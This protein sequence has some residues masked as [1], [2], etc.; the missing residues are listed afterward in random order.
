MP[1][2]LEIYPTRLKVED[3][4]WERLAASGIKTGFT[5]NLLT[6][7]E[8]EKELICELVHVRPISEMERGLL[9]HD[10]VSGVELIRRDSFLA[11]LASSDGFIRS[12]GELIQQFKL[13]LLN[14]REL[15]KIKLFAPSKERWIKSVFERYEKSLKKYQLYDNADIRIKLIESLSDLKGAPRCLARFSE[16]HFYDI[17]HYTPFRFELIRRLGIRMGVGE[18]LVIHFPLP[19]ER[20]KAFDFVERDIQKFQS[21]EDME[22]GLEIAFDTGGGDA[23]TALLNFSNLIFSEKEDENPLMAEKTADSLLITANSSRYREVEEVVSKIRSMEKGNWS[24]FCL[25]FRN[26]ENY[27]SI[28]EDVFRRADIPLYLRRGLPVKNNPLVR[29][30]LTVFTVIETDFD[31]DELVKLATSDYFSLLPHGSDSVALE[32]LFIEAGIMNGPPAS[33]KKRLAALPKKKLARLKKS[34]TVLKKILKLLSLIEKVAKSGRAETVLK[35][36]KSAIK[37][38]SIKPLKQA[39]RYSIRDMSCHA[40]FFELL[41]EMEKLLT[42]KELRATRFGWKDMERLLVNSLG[43]IS[44]PEWSSRNH[45][46]A[47]NVHELAG[48]KFP[49]LFVCGL[50]D[51]EFPQKSTRGSIL[52]EMEKKEFNKIHAETILRNLPHCKRGRQVFSRLGESWEEES[53]LFY[54]ASRSAT[55]KLFLSYSSSDMNGSDLVRSSFIDDVVT[56][57]PGIKEESSKA[58]AIEKGYDEQIDR[59]AREAKLLRDLFN[60]DAE[61]ADTI[62]EYFEMFIGR[63][64]SGRLFSLSGVRSKMERERAGFYSQYYSKNEQAKRRSLSTVYTGKVG[65]LPQVAK[66][67][68]VVNAKGYSPSA[69][70]NYSACPFRYFAGRLLE[71][72]PPEPPRAD[73]ERTA[74]GT[75]IH[76]VLEEYYGSP[77]KFFKRPILKPEKERVEK[78]IEIAESVF[79]KFEKEELKGD[80]ELW[81]IT[82]EHIKGALKLFIAHETGEFEKEP[83]T[84]LA[85]E[86]RFGKG[87]PLFLS[88]S[89]RDIPLAGSV[90]RV[91]Y[92]PKQKAIRVVDYKYTAN[93]SKYKKLLK[94]EAFGDESF[95]MPIYMVAASAETFGGKRPDGVKNLLARY[96]SLKN[97]PDMSIP[98]GLANDGVTAVEQ[99]LAD[100]GFGAKLLS[101]VAKMESGDFSVIPKDCLFCRFKRVCRYEEVRD[102]GKDE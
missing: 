47:L 91:D 102:V 19:D 94:E 99:L 6:V 40:R 101:Q 79:E 17:F 1:E 73:I 7:G 83:F 15:A 50:H 38:L 97:E 51:G 81:K 24:D 26:L 43:N 48:R 39:D 60:K 80:R 45:V 21:L 89:G 69:L 44:V 68:S 41:N 55:K 88:V 56:V 52:A 14:H 10:A 4:L 42:K 92:L 62:R 29:S 57:F 67:F 22:G 33:W 71:C 65:N 86:Y 59:Q 5:E 23:K 18:K 3:V 87:K 49:H 32:N 100:D 2:I 78:I 66:F 76:A 93:H 35:N 36:F 12:M 8:F 70:E 64:E 98:R 46:Y 54:L 16:L 90:D 20:R 61:E 63:K 75:L 30:L 37:L 11:G 25:V 9:L 13:G 85:S 96:L 77:K 72:E 31:R 27:G 95:Q 34:S 53:F 58:V 84:V 74:K 82:K 28:V